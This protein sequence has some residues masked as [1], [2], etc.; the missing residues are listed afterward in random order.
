M[1][2]RRIIFKGKQFTR[3]DSKTQRAEPILTSCFSLSIIESV[4]SSPFTLRLDDGTNEMDETNAD[5]GRSGDGVARFNLR[6]ASKSHRARGHA[7]ANAG[8][9]EGKD[10]GLEE[11][12][13]HCSGSNRY[14]LRNDRSIDV[15][16]G[17]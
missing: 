3:H 12:C 2:H 6:P 4:G 7:T 17:G 16:N 15:S 1:I 8:R 9:T 11:G 5:E 10:E 13:Q 14:W